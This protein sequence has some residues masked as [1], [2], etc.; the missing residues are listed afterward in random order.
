MRLREFLDVN[1][2]EILAR[3]RLRVTA[4]N[5]PRVTDVELRR[6]LPIFLDQ[7]GEALRKATSLEA[8]DH[9]E[10]ASTAT[11]HGDELFHQGLTVAQVVHDY[12]DLCQV[13]TGLAVDNKAPIAAD[14]FRTLNLCL[15]DAIA[16]A[17]TEWARLRERAITHE[18]TERL[19]VLAHEMRNLLSS[20]LLSFES[21]RTGVVAPG[22]STS[23][24]VQRSLMALLALVDRSMAD[25]RL[26]AGIQNL[27]RVAVCEIVGEVEIGAAIT[28]KERGV[29]L[30]VDSVDPSIV[31]RADRQ[32]LAAT[33]SNLL[34][35][36]LKF[37]GAGT[38]VELRA[39]A[40]ATRVL[41][42]VEDECGGLPPGKS[43]S[44]L[45]PFNRQGLD[46][47]G[48]GLGL[49]I[50]LK[51]VKA[52]D[53]ELRIQDLPGKGCIFTI[54]L[55][56]QPPPPTSI[57]AHMRKNDGPTGAGG[58]QVARAV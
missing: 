39:S 23:A 37:T 26:E 2:E 51:A 22:G 58:N 38:T 48:L 10:I 55:P 4:R 1:R 32:I 16:E 33:V 29:S 24:M 40:T 8:A 14:E 13:I 54:D 12:G 17:V 44:L 6:G 36:A 47:T 11:K 25:V 5:F 45:E 19:G 43:E 7:L 31:V 52:I 56:K 15:D 28:A 50:C 30:V 57:H 41:I 34:H 9:A 42:E 21:I 46:R 18:G 53:G 27:E 20:A 35:N 49:S 3:S